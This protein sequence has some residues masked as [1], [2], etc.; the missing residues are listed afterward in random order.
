MR[1]RGKLPSNPIV[2]VV[3][4]IAAVAGAFT[5]RPRNSRQISLPPATV[6][7]PLQNGKARII[8]IV[9]GDTLHALVKANEKSDAMEEKIRLFGINAPELHPKPGTPKESFIPQNFSQE[10][11]DFLAELCPLQSEVTLELHDRDK[12]GRLLAVIVLKDGRSV[13]RLL[14]EK[15]LAKS[16]F[17]YSSKHDPLRD[18]YDAIQQ[19]AMDEKRGIWS[20]P[21]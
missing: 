19:R 9:D 11:C 2:I 5:Q 10:A 20:L 3:L 13:N 14:I 16:Y 18:E 1:T 17:P 7:V 4:L 15:G 12:Y 8:K 21:R 6:Q